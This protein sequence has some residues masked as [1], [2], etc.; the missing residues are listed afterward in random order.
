MNQF[1]RSQVN[2]LNSSNQ[3]TGQLFDFINALRS[4]FEPAKPQSNLFKVRT[5]PCHSNEE[6]ERKA[7]FGFELFQGIGV[8]GTIVVEQQP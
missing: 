6:I 2:G 3:G 5:S 7:A 8:E 4:D 1:R